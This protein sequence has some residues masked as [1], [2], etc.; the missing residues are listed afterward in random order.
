[1]RK[2]TSSDPKLVLSL[3]PEYS[4]AN[5]NFKYLDEEHTIKRLGIVWN[6]SSNFRFTTSK[7]MSLKSETITK[8]Q[9]LS[10]IAQTFDPFDS[11]TPFIISL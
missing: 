9:T 6:P 11:L 7:S 1:M 10:D 8:R 5:G 3:P 4:G 2:W